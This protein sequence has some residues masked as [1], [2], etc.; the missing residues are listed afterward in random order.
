MSM[1]PLFWPLWFRF[2]NL[3]CIFPLVF[4]SSVSKV[5][6]DGQ[7]SYLFIWSFHIKINLCYHQLCG[8]SFQINPNPK[9]FYRKIISSTGD[10]ECLF[11]STLVLQCVLLIIIVCLRSTRNETVRY[12]QMNYF[13]YLEVSFLQM[14]SQ[15]GYISVF[16]SDKERWGKKARRNRSD[17]EKCLKNSCIL[18]T[19]QSLLKLFN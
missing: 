13:W 10:W 17:T 9:M 14:L 11:N 18:K 5:K 6:H 1:K 16:R 15:W 12:S 2:L 19:S 7:C 3:K 4:R 8:C